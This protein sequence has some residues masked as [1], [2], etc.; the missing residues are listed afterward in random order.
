MGMKFKT[1][2]SRAD[3]DHPYGVCLE[4]F[5]DTYEITFTQIEIDNWCLEQFG[6][7]GDKWAGV[8]YVGENYIRVYFKS[9]DDRNWFLLRWT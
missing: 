8:M 6:P 1:F 3:L 2:D 9:I 5:G 4:V 7:D